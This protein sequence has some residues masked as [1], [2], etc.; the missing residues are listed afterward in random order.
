MGYIRGVPVCPSCH[1]TIHAGAEQQCP[2]CGYSLKRAELLFGEGDIEFTRVVDEAGALMHSERME[3]IRLLEDLERNISPVALG[4][5]ITSHGQAK[6]F[7]AHAHWVLNH[8]HIHHPSF[9]RREQVRAIEEA[10]LVMGRRGEKMPPEPSSVLG[11]WWERARRGLRDLVHPY[12]PPVRKEWMLILVLDVQLELACFSW[13][14]MLDPYIN[15][16]S[17]NSCIIGARLYFRERAMAVGLRRVMKAVTAQIAVRSHR[18]NR[19]MRNSLLMHGETLAIAA[20]LCGSI[21]QGAPVSLPSLEDDAP[22]EEVEERPSVPPSPPAPQSPPE[23]KAVPPAPQTH[24]AATGTRRPQWDETEYRHLLS[25]ELQG[26]YSLLVDPGA[27]KHPP[28][29]AATSGKLRAGE[30]RIPRRYYGVYAQPTSSCLVDPQ[31]LLSS[32][33][34]AD[35]EY[36]LKAFNAHAP[37]TLYIALFKSA[38][39]IPMEISVGTLVRSLAAPGEYAVL[40]LYGLGDIPRLEVGYH[41]IDLKDGDRHAWQEK[42]LLAARTHGSGVSG[43]LAAAGSLHDSL[44]PATASLP[45]QEQRTSLQVPLIPVEMREDESAEEVTYKDELLMLMENP[46][47]RHVLWG[48][49]LLLVP[50]LLFVALY[51]WRRHF[52]RLLKS[53]PDVRLGAPFGSGVSRNVHYLEGREVKKVSK[54]F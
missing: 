12:P 54:L 3:L 14:Y 27:P 17:I 6:D 25:G 9:G 23:Q 50:V 2:V 32:V 26:C 44:Q 33:E 18:L 5:Y 8:A 35:V 39:E 38:Q 51:F 13:G 43:L 7:R 15:P 16:D 31:G 42:A 37:Y 29:E 40:L 22:A 34:R 19:R 53:E 10:E 4:I 41:E 11:A 48:L 47:M 52:G 36:A 20:A 49:C 28:T 1:S 30:T 21:V 45:P 24:R 46:Y